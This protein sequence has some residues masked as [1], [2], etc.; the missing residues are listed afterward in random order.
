MKYRIDID[1]VV[2]LLC[3]IMLLHDAQILMQMYR[4][5]KTTG[6]AAASLD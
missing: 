1:I 4:T 5:V 2:L 6:R 3:L